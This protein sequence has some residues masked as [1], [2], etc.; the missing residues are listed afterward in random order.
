MSIGQTWTEE[1]HV[2]CAWELLQQEAS[3]TAD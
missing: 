2:R 1:R 3:A